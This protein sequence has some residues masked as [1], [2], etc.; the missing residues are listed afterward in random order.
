[1]TSGNL[2]TFQWIEAVPTD[3]LALIDAIRQLSRHL[4]GLRAVN[5]SWDS[6]LLVPSDEERRHGW[7]VQ[8]GR[9]VSPVIDDGLIDTWP[10]CDGGFEEWYFFATLPRDL[11]LA[12]YCNWT[13]L[14]IDD[15][16][17]LVE[18]PGGFDLHKQLDTAQPTLV[19][20]E[21][22]RL[23]AISPNVELIDDLAKALKAT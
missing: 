10:W 3:D 20:G 22:Q 12:A 18:M 9:A 16:R 8:D 7:T 19:I 1:M 4:I 23:F 21:G 17:L 14:S 5:V 11:N 6:G 15:W 13:G 2:G